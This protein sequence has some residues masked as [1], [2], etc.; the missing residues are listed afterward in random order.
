MSTFKNKVAI[1]TGS[2]QGIGKT[3]AIEMCKKGAS[4]VLN[5]RT[6]SKLIKTLE[7]L[8]VLGHNVIAIKGDITSLKDCKRIVAKTIQ[9][10]GQI[11]FLINNGSITMQDEID[12]I[13][14]EAFENVFS[15]NS[16]GA[17]YPTKAALPF[18]KKTKGSVIFISS[19]AGLHAMPSASGY[20]M[21]KMALSSLWQSLSIELSHTGIHFGICYLSFTQSEKEK[22]M[23]TA[24]GN[25]VPV[26]KRPSYI[27]QSQKTVA[28]SIMRVIK[29][30]KSKRVFS[31]FG[32]V[33]SVF[34]RFFPGI[35][36]RIMI[37]NQKKQQNHSLEPV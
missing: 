20:S 37:L 33:V 23:L 22:T 2:S 32:N 9:T 6:E 21:G 27:L 14:T 12:C 4:V 7:E 26:P 15:S 28:K 1:I 18:L 35:V 24:N 11:D 5:G 8:K 16:M 19:L 25:C 36:M 31:I 17:F 3:L 10:F 34:F 13:E 29:Y 30:R